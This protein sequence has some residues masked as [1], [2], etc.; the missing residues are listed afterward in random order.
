MIVP[1]EDRKKFCLTEEE[2]LEL[3]KWG[4]ENRRTLQ[5]T[6][7][8]RMGQRR[9]DQGTLYRPGPSGNSAI[10]KGSPSF[11]RIYIREKKQST[12][13]CGRRVGGKIGQ[14][15]ANVIKDVAKIA[16]FKKGEVLV[17][18]MTDPDW[19]PI[20]K[21]ATAIVTNSGGRTS[22][23]AIVSRELGIPCIVGAGNATHAI[24]DAQP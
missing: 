1:A 13:T 10:A 21:I 9:T 7:G 17:T 6:D 23:A 20:M 4:A 15:K 2:V 19:E 16:D 22:H 14:G 3:A 18:E 11:G 12:L 24:Q 8:H 5:K